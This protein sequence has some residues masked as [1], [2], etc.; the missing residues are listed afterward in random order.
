MTP[1]ER[2]EH[3]RTAHE[4]VLNA[5]HE[6]SAAR[7]ALWGVKG[8]GVSDELAEIRKRLDVMIAEWDRR[9]SP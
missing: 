4:H 8:D 5:I 3:V 7:M 6:M 2:A 1:E 9:M